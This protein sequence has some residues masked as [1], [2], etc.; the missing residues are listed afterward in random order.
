MKLAKPYSTEKETF[1]N[2]LLHPFYR[3]E[4]IIPNI[5]NEM[6]FGEY[7]FTPMIGFLSLCGLFFLTFLIAIYGS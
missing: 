5:N 2:F 3:R 6:M 7:E 1:L 4:K